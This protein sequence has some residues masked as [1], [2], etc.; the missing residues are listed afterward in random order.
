VNRSPASPDMPNG[1]GTS[2]QI[3]HGH[4]AGPIATA[5]RACLSES[6]FP[7]HYS[8]PEYFCEPIR[9]GNNPFAVL[10]MV[11]EDVT[12]VMTGIHYSDRVQSGLSN[13]PQ[14]AFSRHADRSRAMSN[15]IA[16]LLQEAGSASL[17]D[18]FL[19]SDMAGL[20]DARFRQ[21]P[22]RG[23]VMLDL[24][25]GPD[26]LFRQFSQARRNRIR[27]AIKYGVSVEPAESCDDISAYY[28]VY[29]DWARRMC[30]EIAGEEQF[31]EEFLTTRKNR[32]LLLARHNGEVI[33]GVVLRFFPGGVVEHAWHSSLE[34]A[35]Y[36]RPND[37]LHWRA[38]EWACTNG[39]TKYGLG[40]TNLFLRQFG[41][42]IVR[43]TRHRLDR[44]LFRRHTISDWMIDRV[45]EVRPFMPQRVVGLA[46][47]LR[48]HVARLRYY[49]RRRSG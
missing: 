48:D 40:S 27:R 36:M 41:G 10:S 28:A 26:A 9:Y 38:I 46:S 17:V 47:S 33:A 24:S 3:L 42:E 6:D 18:L 22:C 29:V 1:Q 43:T 25:L 12:A 34:S 14:I 21:R 7:T 39:L 32:Q 20:V 5:W 19:W 30:W 8:A 4:P 13:R 23:V 37:L 31:Q 44:S 2:F 16:G 45:E 11:R 49:A 35:L 15:L